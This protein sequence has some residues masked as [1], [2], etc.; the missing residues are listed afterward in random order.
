[1]WLAR[2]VR[3]VSVDGDALSLFE[4]SVIFA[5]MWLLIIS[6]R[7]LAGLAEAAERRNRVSL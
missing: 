1:M 4:S 6:G 7:G 5:E 2:L 3:L